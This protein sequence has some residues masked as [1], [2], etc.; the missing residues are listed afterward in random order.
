MRSFLRF[1]AILAVLV[2]LALPARSVVPDKDI[3]TTF[4][5]LL[6]ELQG[7]YSSVLHS[8]SLLVN[9]QLRR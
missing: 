5:N 9:S 8:D 3:Q 6:Q 4:T 1:A 7:A 2:S